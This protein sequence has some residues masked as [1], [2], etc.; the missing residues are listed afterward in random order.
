MVKP[1]LFSD[2]ERELV[3]VSADTLKNKNGRLRAGPSLGG[4]LFFAMNFAGSNSDRDEKQPING[5]HRIA[6]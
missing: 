1:A 5:A 3:G 2:S 6:E 4:T